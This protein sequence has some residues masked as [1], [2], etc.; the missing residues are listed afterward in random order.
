MKTKNILLGILIVIGLI[1]IVGVFR[2]HNIS[3]LIQQS[4]L[5]RIQDTK[6]MRVG[7]A[8]Y[9]PYVIKD[10][11][12]GKLSGYYIDIMNEMANRMGVKIEWIETTWNTYIT[13]LQTGKFDVIDDP[14]FTS[15]PRWEQIS[16][17]S[18]L[19]Y[20]SGVAGLAKGSENRFAKLDNLNQKGITIAVPQGWTAQDYAT[21][22]LTNATVKSFPGDTAALAFA[23]V[24]A[25][26]SAIALADGP[27]VQQYIEQNL[28]QNVKALFLDNPSVI[29][30]AAWGIKK[31]DLEWLTFL[32]GSIE[33][34]RTDGTLKKIA[35]KYHLYSYDVE[36]KFAPQ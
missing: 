16:F 27:S 17:T 22:Y 36:S 15:I 9:P 21:K 23:D 13:D 11:K 28:N 2:N 35:Q 10:L 6:I 25:G 12:T 8:A 14:M 30:P 34:M 1:L 32:N 4:T 29:T 31:G 7:Y 19:G 33:S 18:P 24:V 5:T 20:F 26:N 3:N